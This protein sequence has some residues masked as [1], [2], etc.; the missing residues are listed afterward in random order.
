VADSSS[1]P[2][3]SLSLCVVLRLV[4]AVAFDELVVGVFARFFGI[5]H[6]NHL[7]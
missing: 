5:R 7:R 2:K 3:L 4:F 6:Q 1:N